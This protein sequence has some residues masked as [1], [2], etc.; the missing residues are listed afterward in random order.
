MFNKLLQKEKRATKDEMV[1]WHHWFNGHELEQT[2]WDSEGQGRPACCSPRGCED[3]VKSSWLN[4]NMHFNIKPYHTEA[5][6]HKMN[7]KIMINWYALFI[8]CYIINYH[9]QQLE[10]TH[11]SYSFYGSGIWAYPNWVLCFS[12][13]HKAAVRES[14]KTDSLYRG[15]DRE[16][17][18][19]KFIWH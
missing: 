5:T 12:L 17:F 16:I 2:P 8:Y 19:S 7:H 6:S 13:S 3:S 11:L 9:K 10:T 15:S 14:S 18:N 4:N 1:G